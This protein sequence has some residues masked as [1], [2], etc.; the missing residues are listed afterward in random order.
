MNPA[1]VQTTAPLVLQF[2]EQILE[3][4]LRIFIPSLNSIYVYWS[5]M[6]RQKGK[7]PPYCFFRHSSLTQNGDLNIFIANM[8]TVASSPGAALK[9]ERAQDQREHNAVSTPPPPPP[10][11]W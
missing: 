5:H 10:P 2:D 3:I 7:M 8:G 1:V 4:V 11:L 6:L 9:C